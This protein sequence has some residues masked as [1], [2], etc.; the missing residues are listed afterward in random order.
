MPINGCKAWSSKYR[1]IHVRHIHEPKTKD[2]WSQGNIVLNQTIQL[3]LLITYYRPD[4]ASL[5]LKSCPALRRYRAIQNNIVGE[6]KKEC[7]VHYFT[8]EVNGLPRPMV[9]PLVPSGILGPLE[10]C[11]AD[12]SHWDA[13]LD[14]GD[15]ACLLF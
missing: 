15:N 1:H 7:V 4:Y 5:L 13:L 2:V 11:F 8:E 3:E 10:I 9:K 14:C 6:K 12:A